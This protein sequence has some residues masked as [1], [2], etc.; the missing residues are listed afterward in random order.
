MVGNRTAIWLALALWA[1][2]MLLSCL[3]LT[4]EPTGDGF[5][6]GLNRVAGFIGWQLPAAVLA[7]FLWLSSRPLR[8]GEVLRWLARVPG[9]WAVALLV[10][11]GT[12]MAVG[13]IGD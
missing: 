11:I 4:A 3:S 7:L 13:L 8:K 12:W 6:R 10:L 9:W 5:T 2:A 1:G